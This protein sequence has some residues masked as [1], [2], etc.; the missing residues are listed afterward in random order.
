MKYRGRADDSCAPCA[1]ASGPFLTCDC[2]SA[3]CARRA[4][5]IWRDARAAAAELAPAQAPNINPRHHDAIQYYPDEHRRRDAPQAIQDPDEAHHRRRGRHL[6]HSRHCRGDGHVPHLHA[7]ADQ[8]HE[9][10]LRYDLAGNLLNHIRLSD[11][12][13]ADAAG[14]APVAFDSTKFCAE[15]RQAYDEKCQAANVTCKAIP[16]DYCPLSN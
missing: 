9:H 7:Q 5:C 2:H 6:V 12:V 14:V 10:E 16:D 1:L 8:P 3:L 15:W 4:S 13:A 11:V